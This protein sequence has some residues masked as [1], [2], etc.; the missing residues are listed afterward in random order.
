MNREHVKEL[1]KVVLYDVESLNIDFDLDDNKYHYDL[2]CGNLKDLITGVK[3][4]KNLI[5]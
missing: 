1:L 2:A 4:W 5:C 3:Q